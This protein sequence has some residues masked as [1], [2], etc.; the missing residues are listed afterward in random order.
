LEKYGNW[1]EVKDLERL[2]KHALKQAVALKGGAKS[3]VMVK[4]ATDSA[5]RD[6]ARLYEQFTGQ[7]LPER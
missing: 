6:A 1:Y 4:F 7:P 2:P 3:P 5:R